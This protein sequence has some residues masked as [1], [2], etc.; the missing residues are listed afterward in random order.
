M[1]CY[2]NGKKELSTSLFERMQIQNKSESESEKSEIGSDTK[3]ESKS[4]LEFDTE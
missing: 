4:E 2:E 1:F 3:L